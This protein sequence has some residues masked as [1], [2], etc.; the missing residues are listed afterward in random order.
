MP[1]FEPGGRGSVPRLRV[2]VLALLFLGAIAGTGC[3]EADTQG[4]AGKSPAVD[5]EVSVPVPDS[6]TDY[7]VFTGRTQ[8]INRLDVRSRV[9]GYLDVVYVGKDANVSE[10]QKIIKEGGDVKKGDILFVIHQEPFEAALKQAQANREQ[11]R[12]TIA[13]QEATRLAQEEQARYNRSYYD[14]YVKAGP[15]AASADDIEKAYSGWKTAVEAA[16]AAQAAKEAAMA[17]ERGAEAAEAIAAQN[18][19]WTTIRAPFNGRIGKRL[20]DRGNDVIA[21]NTI[22][23]TLE[24]IDP[25]YAYFDVDERTLLK[26]SHLLPEGQVPPDAAQKLPLKLGLANEKPEN[27]SHDGQLLFADNRVD[28]N[29]GTLR[30][31]GLFENPKL[32]LRSG[33]FVRV[34]VGIGDPRQVLFVNE[35]ALGSDQGWRYLYVVNAENKIDRV[36]VEVGQRKNGL[37]AIEKGLEPGQRIVVIGLQRVRRGDK[38]EPKLV[39]MPR[40]EAPATT[41][42]VVTEQG[43]RPK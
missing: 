12:K 26:I 42:P 35:S 32:D 31:W 30:M 1:T 15:S 17:A 18:L 9:T 38:V 40:L 10:G 3:G 21:D 11:A 39:E 5:V 41:T 33:L 19:D 23:A 37:I 34:R 36:P 16:K 25:L 28:A 14:R 2:L 20:V 8:A 29:T 27:F 7:E 43:K 6:I 24:Q 13:Q 4:A 22:L